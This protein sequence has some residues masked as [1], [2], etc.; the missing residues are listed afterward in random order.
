M[1]PS[2]NGWA[3]TMLQS[4]A[5][6]VQKSSSKMVAAPQR[7]GEGDTLADLRRLY[8]QAGRRGEDISLTCSYKN[9]FESFSLSGKCRKVP[10]GKGNNQRAVAPSKPPPSS[11]Q[12]NRKERRAVDP[13]VKRAAAAHTAKQAALTAVERAAASA[14]APILQPEMAGAV[15]LGPVHVVAEEAKK[16]ELRPE[17]SGLGCEDKVTELEKIVVEL[18]EE[19]ENKDS[20]IS[21]CIFRGNYIDKKREVYNT[22]VL[23]IAKEWKL[24]KYC[25]TCEPMVGKHVNELLVEDKKIIKEHEEMRQDMEKEV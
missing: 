7:R 17:K 2:G 21:K 19:I 4:M 24:K 10:D 11:Q 16:S 6:Q 15:G 22:F 20:L 12:P 14:L 3:L 8:L 9:G 25:K 13:D 18:K 23:K 1:T 5:D